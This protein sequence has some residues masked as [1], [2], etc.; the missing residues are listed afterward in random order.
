[1]GQPGLVDPLRL[2]RQDADL[3]VD[4]GVQQRL[5]AAGGRAVGVAN[6]DDDP[7]H[8]GLDQGP[9]AGRGAAG[10]V[11]RL[12]RHDSGAAPGARARLAQR[13]DLRVGTAGPLVVALADDPAGGVDDHAADDGVGGGRAD[14]SCGQGDGAAHRGGLAGGRHLSPSSRLHPDGPG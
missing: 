5:H 2:V 7:D 13:Q 12:Q 6:R 9:A 4:A 10:V 8:A 3:H 14:P 1:V 11:A